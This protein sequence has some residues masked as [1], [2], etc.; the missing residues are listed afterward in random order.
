MAC[1]HRPGLP[2]AIITR[3]NREIAGIVAL[4]DVKV[5]FQQLG[6]EAMSGTP[7]DCAGRIRMELDKWGRIIRKRNIKID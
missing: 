7:A 2:P 1:S 5:R 6:I 4:P 3:L